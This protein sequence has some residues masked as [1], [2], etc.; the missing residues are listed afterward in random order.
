MAL[1]CDGC[2][3]GYNFE[4]AQEFAENALVLQ[5]GLMGSRSAGPVL[6]SGALLV[7]ASPV[8]PSEDATG[9]GRPCPDETPEEPAHLGNRK[10]QHVCREVEVLSP[11]WRAVAQRPDKQGPAWPAGR[12]DAT[13]SRSGP[14]THRAQPR[15]WR[16]QS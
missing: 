8:R 11:G 15:P 2:G 1:G 6:S 10:G 7:S 4:A 5:P 12:D 3:S 16:P 9:I 14:R 13:P